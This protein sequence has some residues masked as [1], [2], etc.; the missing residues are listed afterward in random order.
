MKYGYIPA[1][2]IGN[3]KAPE[4]QSYLVFNKQLSYYVTAKEI[5]EKSVERS[6]QKT[7][8]ND[9]G[10]GSIYNGIKM[11]EEG[12]QV[13]NHL[14]KKTMWSNLLYRKQVYTKETTPQFNWKLEKEIKKI[15]KFTCK[16]ATAN[17]RGRNYTAW[18][19]PE[20]PLPFG[21]WK[22]NGLPGLILEAYDTNKYVYWYSQS[23]EYPSNTKEEPKY[24][25]IPKNENFLSLEGF[26]NFQNAELE[27]LDEKSKIVKKNHPNV[28]FENNFNLCEMFV[29]C[30]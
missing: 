25:G 8:T 2:T 15:G 1:L 20:I 27:R 5:L 4:N 22:L 18:Y 23:I 28:Q 6:N 26:K 9:D 30:K 14:A 7:F 24:F 12:D 17:F 29:E 10:G 16:K 13:V 19:A 11:S 3:A 21:P